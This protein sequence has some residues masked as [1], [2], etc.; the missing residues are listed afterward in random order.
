MLLTCKINR[1]FS[2][3]QITLN[4][5]ELMLMLVRTNFIGKTEMHLE[6]IEQFKSEMEGCPV[7]VMPF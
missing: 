1:M 4:V 5:A 2:Q 7:R 6:N 3:D